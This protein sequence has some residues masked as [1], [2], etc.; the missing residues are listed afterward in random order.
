M[1]DNLTE[2]YKFVEQKRIALNL[3]SAHF[4][5]A[6]KQGSGSAALT[7]QDKLEDDEE[8]RGAEQTWGKD[9]GLESR[10]LS[11]RGE[12]L[13]RG[14]S[15][16]ESK[17]EPKSD[18]KPIEIPPCPVCKAKHKLFNCDD[19]KAQTLSLHCCSRLLFELNEHRR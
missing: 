5:P 17:G 4:A 19:F 13:Q 7:Q 15:R 16:G 6:P 10:E 3:A 2:F 8:E 11:K 14:E 12:P 9:Y 18:P 1:I